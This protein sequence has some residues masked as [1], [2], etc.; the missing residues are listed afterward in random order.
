MTPDLRLHH[1]GILVGDIP[2]SVAQYV[3]R[4]GYQVK[5]DLIHDPK[6][7]ARVQFVRLPGDSVYLEFVTP[8]GPQSR[9]SGALSKG[10]GLHHLCYSADDID[11]AC[12]DLRSKGMTLVRPPIPAVAFEG[13]RIAWLMGRDRLLMELVERGP[14]GEL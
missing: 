13:R 7:Q 8:D 10:G 4:F 2:D 11:S 1:V 5:S 14:E 3:N 6:Q 9:L 12:A